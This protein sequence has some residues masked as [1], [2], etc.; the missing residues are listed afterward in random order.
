MEYKIE[1]VINVYDGDTFT[2]DINLGMDIILS[3]QKFR[4]LGID[5]LEIKGG[6]DE[7]KEKAKT[8]RDFVRSKKLEKVSIPN[9]NKKDKYGRW[10]CVVYDENGENINSLLLSKGLAKEYY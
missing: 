1:K 10:L 7:E 3:H 8:A 2:A 5:T 4:L 9:G 6:T